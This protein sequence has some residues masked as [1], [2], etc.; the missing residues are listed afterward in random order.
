MFRNHG[1]RAEFFREFRN[2]PARL[3]PWAMCSA[4]LQLH[5]THAGVPGNSVRMSREIAR[6]SLRH[7]TVSK[8]TTSSAA[9]PATACSTATVS[10]A[11]SCLQR[12]L[13]PFV[14]SLISS[15]ARQTAQLPQYRNAGYTRQ[16]WVFPVFSIQILHVWNMIFHRQVKCKGSHVGAWHGSP[17]FAPL[18]PLRHSCHRTQTHHSGLRHRARLRMPLRASCHTLLHS[19]HVSEAGLDTIML[20]EWSD[21]VR[22]Y[23]LHLSSRH[24][25]E[26]G[27]SSS[28]VEGFACV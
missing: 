23:R 6:S 12:Q 22:A 21:M 26:L 7:G 28:T 2:I 3:S 20:P 14:L 19:I 11:H 24:F 5:A 1:K 10:A 17:L 9:S 27:A 8:A 13:S 16:G 18:T 25:R 4:S 15:D